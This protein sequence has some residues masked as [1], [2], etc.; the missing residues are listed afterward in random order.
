MAAA[1]HVKGDDK[2]RHD[3]RCSTSHQSVMWAAQLCREAGVLATTTVP[4]CLW[5]IQRYAAYRLKVLRKTTLTHLARLLRCRG[6]AVVWL[7]PV[8]AHW[9]MGISRLCSD[10]AMYF[11]NIKGSCRCWE[12]AAVSFAMMWCLHGALV[13]LL[14]SRLHLSDVAPA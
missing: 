2:S 11:L 4:Q 1:I 5:A 12:L 9:R 6:P 14:R 13:A 3:S 7:R 8:L 10:K